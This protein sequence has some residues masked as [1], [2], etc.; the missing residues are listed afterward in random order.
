MATSDPLGDRMKSYEALTRTSLPRRSFSI[1]RVDGRAFHTWTRGLDRPF[2]ADLADAMDDTARRLTAAVQGAIVGFVESDEISVV[3]A[4]LGRESTQAWFGGEVQ[5]QVSIAAA[6]AAAAFAVA[7]DLRGRLAGKPLATF[8]ARVFTVPDAVEAA[9][10]LIWRQRDAERNSVSMA[11]QAGV[12]APA[13]AGCGH[14]RDAGDASGAGRRL[15]CVP[16]EVQAWWDRD[17]TDR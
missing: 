5:K 17:E 7:C 12:L 10:Y 15:G 8:D 3:Y 13:V 11:A 14:G 6:T 16:G 2:D 9:N 4:D 1:L